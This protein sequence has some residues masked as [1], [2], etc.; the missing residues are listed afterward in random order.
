MKDKVVIVTGGSR[1]IGA[2]TAALLASAGARVAI[3]SRTATELEATA[4]VIA[5]QS[6]AERVLAVPTDVAEERSVVGLFE[7][8][9][10]RFGDLDVLVNNAG[11]SAAAISPIS[12]PRPGT[13]YKRS[14]CAVHFSRAG[15][16][17]ADFAPSGTAARSST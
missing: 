6:G 1:G 9:V 17:S 3:A 2:A 14:T 12:R 16:P 5:T 8:V 7:A 10:A 11:S 4:R 13:A 15:R